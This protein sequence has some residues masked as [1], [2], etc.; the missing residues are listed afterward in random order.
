VCGL[1]AIFVS[2]A[3]HENYSFRKYRT[4]RP[5]A[6]AFVGTLFCAALALSQFTDKIAKIS[7]GTA[8]QGEPLTI[9]VDLQ[10]SIVL[11]GIEIAYRQFGERDFKYSEM[12]LVGTTAT[13]TLPAETVLPPF[14]EYYLLLNVRGTSSPETYPLENPEQQPLKIIVENL[15]PEVRHVVILSPDRNEKV[16]QADLLISF[17]L[18]QF[19]SSIDKAETKI[20]LDDID[21]SKIAVRTGDIIIV[22]PENASLYLESG[23]HTIRVELTSSTGEPATTFSW[24]FSILA[25][26]VSSTIKPVSPWVYGSSLQLETRQEKVGNSTT[27]F[28][29]ATMAAFGGYNNIRIKGN[30]FLTNEEKDYRQPQNRYFIGAESPWIK[31]GYGDTYPVISDLIMS[32]KRIRGVSGSVSL[33]SFNVDVASGTVIRKFEG[34]SG[35]LIPDSSLAD[36]QSKIGDSS[37]TFVRFDS[38]ADGWRWQKLY[39]GTFERNMFVVRTIFGQRD[40]S[41]IAFS[42][43]HSSDDKNSIR[44]GIR[45]RENVVFGSDF[46]ASLDSRRIEFNGQV[47]F[48]AVNNDISHGSISDED[49][50]S[51]FKDNSD[52]VRNIRNIFSNIITVNEYLVPLG[53]KHTPTLAYEGGA[54][55][56]YFNNTFRFTYLRHGASYESFGQSYIRTDVVGYNISDRQRLIDNQ[57]FLSGGYERLKDNTVKIKATTTTTTTANV[58]VSYYPKINF[59][60]LTVGYLLASNE[61][62]LI[63]TNPLSINDKTDRVVFQIGKELSYYCRHNLTLNI[64]TSVRDD[65]TAT[66]YDTRNLSISLG[67]YATFAFPLQATVNVTMNSSKFISGITDTSRILNKFSYTTLYTNIQYNLLSDRLLLNSSFSPTIGDI[68]RVLFG[69]GAQYFFWRN[70]SAQ[71]QLTLYFNSKM[72]GISVSSTDIVWN[73]VLRADI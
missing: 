70:I 35:G 47:A 72:Y 69:A 31:I 2:C 33:G 40:G 19:D 15:A 71:T 36:E 5:L 10:Q 12:S 62:G 30:L 64:S 39:P 21:L 45:P 13:F 49:I 11:D 9:Q 66:D 44:Y 53:M 4:V 57:L 24:N 7:A 22:K 26:A 27:P 3:E 50:D 54:A 25:G 60:N 65:Q 63:G 18:A 68:Q 61:N 43:L 67:D 34:S 46:F 41:H 1:T 16:T 8:R 37:I 14:V 52:M 38:T 23:A 56:N 59:P 29:R 55:L 51:L 17:S 48:S 28:N 20:F 42:Y 73:F 58:S 6:I 32:G